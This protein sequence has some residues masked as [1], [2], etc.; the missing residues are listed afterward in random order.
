MQKWKQERGYDKPLLFNA[1]AEGAGK[2]TDTIFFEKSVPLF[3]FDFGHAEDGRDIAHEIRDAHVA[4]PRASPLPVFLVGLLVLHHLRAADGVF[5]RH[6]HRLLAVSCCAWS[7]CRSPAL[8]YIIGGQ[9]V[10]SKL[11]NLVPISGY[12]GGFERWQVPGAAG[13]HRRDR[14]HRREQRAGIARIFLEEI[15]TRLRAHRARQGTVRSA[16]AVPPCAAERA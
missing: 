11:W 6:L 7:R 8:F 9:Y 5:P 14:R 15:N 13:A 3:W 4:E 12:A 2:L 10:I 16:R 1:K